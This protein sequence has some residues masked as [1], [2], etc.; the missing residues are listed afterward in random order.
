MD[1]PY[2]KKSS[3]RNKSASKKTQDQKMLDNQAVKALKKT[4]AVDF[5]LSDDFLST[6]SDQN[7]CV[8]SDEIG[9]FSLI[10]KDFPEV[11]YKLML[12]IK[13]Y[14]ELLF[15]WGETYKAIEYC[16]IASGAFRLLK[17]YNPIFF[18]ADP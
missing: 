18:S 6:N 9:K 2:S 10:I 17:L 15:A 14:S 8:E 16:K 5:L 12:Y 1:S 7:I 3:K 11:A 13:S 4:V